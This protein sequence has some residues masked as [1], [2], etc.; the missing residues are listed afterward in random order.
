[1]ILI[2]TGIGTLIHLLDGS[3]HEESDGDTR[4][5]PESVA[6]FMPFSSRRELPGDVHRLEGVGS[7]PHF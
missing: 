6:A 7:S 5:L 3:M 4:V 1:M 2:I